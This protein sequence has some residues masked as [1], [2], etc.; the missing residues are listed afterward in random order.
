MSE[1]D[2][3][4]VLIWKDGDFTLSSEVYEAESTDSILTVDN[5]NQLITLKLADELSL[6]ERRTIERRIQ[7]IAKSG[8]FV[9]K[10]NT[11]I[12]MNFRLE[13][14]N[15]NESIPDNLLQEGHKY[16]FQGSDISKEGGTKSATIS[17]YK[18]E[19][20]TPTFSEIEKD[21]ESSVVENLDIFSDPK[22]VLGRFLVG[23]LEKSELFISKQEEMYIL[24]FS[25]GRVDF[26]IE[27][28]KIKIISKKK[29]S[30][31]DEILMNAKDFAEKNL[32]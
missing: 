14:A 20:S 22:S 7:S 32:L 13:K 9:S 12:G 16:T 19:N 21:N 5:N 8:Y 4:I 18:D 29:I 24:E 6:I 26:L 15:K 25:S 10:L 28:G 23:I 3:I 17:T 11:R 27:A 2:T 31:E 1:E 30:D